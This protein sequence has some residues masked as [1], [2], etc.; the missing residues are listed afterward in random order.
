MPKSNIAIVT[1]TN[2]G[3]F[4]EEGQK[5]GITVIRMPFFLNGKQYYENDD[6]SAKDFFETMENNPNIE[7]S[8]S[9]PATG[10]IY[11]IWT[12]L[13]KNHDEVVY[14]PM[15]SGLSSSCAAASQIAMEFDGKVQ[16]VN[17]QRI[18][19]TQTQ[20]VLDAI[21]LKNQGK[22]AKEIKA[23]LEEQKYDSSIYISVGSL[24]YLK[25]GGRVTP[26]A[27]L[28][29][30]MLKIKPVLQIQGEKLD[31]FAKSHGIKAA[32]KTMIKAIK[33]DLDGRFK[34]YA[35]K[36]EMRVFIAYTYTDEQIIQE[37]L[38]EVQTAFPKHKIVA[39]QLSL[40]ISCHTGPGCLAIGC[41]RIIK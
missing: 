8:T 10:E 28:L 33:K 35:D 34:E 20:S 25:K 18:S 29:G 37:W 27:A 31:S 5:L 38:D 2:S 6:L 7:F 17:N 24:D 15:S 36:D 13:L 30:G 26:A 4:P 41:A 9:M 19:L 21:T 12:E 3:I 1:D 40:S 39:Q 32:K 11:T 14:I 22:S 23:I 16:V